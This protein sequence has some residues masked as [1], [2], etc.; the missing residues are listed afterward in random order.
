[1]LGAERRERRFQPGCEGAG[2]IG[3]F[4]RTCSGGVIGRRGQVFL[5]A[6]D[7]HAK[8]SAGLQIVLDESLT[9]TVRCGTARG[10]GLSYQAMP[11]QG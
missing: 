4:G 11:T 2:K 1:M 8:K 6:D 7:F 10:S 9:E 5:C 3:S